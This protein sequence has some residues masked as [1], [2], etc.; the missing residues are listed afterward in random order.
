MILTKYTIKRSDNFKKDFKKIRSDR[1]LQKRLQKKMK[2][3]VINPSHYKNLRNVLK[4]RQR[5]HIGSFVLVFEVNEAEK[6]VTF[7]KFRHHDKVYK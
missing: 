7:Y 3:I 1:V 6:I 5:V 2:E 4:N